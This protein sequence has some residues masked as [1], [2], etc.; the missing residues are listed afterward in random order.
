M[1]LGNHGGH[2][3]PILWCSC[4]CKEEPSREFWEVGM[5]FSSPMER[6]G[7]IWATLLYNF[8]IFKE[9][10][11]SGIQT[12]LKEGQIN[13]LK[14]FFPPGWDRLIHHQRCLE[15]LHV[16]HVGFLLVLLTNDLILVI[17]IPTVNFAC[18]AALFFHGIV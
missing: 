13:L 2:F 7:R 10:M 3:G 9:K 4:D 6:Q 17:M 8:A 1:L 18:W 15:L 11:G 14:V 12:G 16:S 5:A